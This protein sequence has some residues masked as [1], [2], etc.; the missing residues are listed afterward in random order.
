[1]VGGVVGREHKTAIFSHAHSIAVPLRTRPGHE[2]LWDAGLRRPTGQGLVGEARDTQVAGI[3]RG[4]TNFPHCK[5]SKSMDTNKVQSLTKIDM[6][7]TYVA[8]ILTIMLHICKSRI[9][10]T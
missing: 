1:M 4:E 8:Y 5:Q 2:G 3:D 7:K 10:V 9:S 6:C